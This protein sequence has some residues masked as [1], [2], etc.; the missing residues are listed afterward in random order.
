[1][2]PDTVKADGLAAVEA[3]VRVRMTEQVPPE[4][5]E[6]WLRGRPVVRGVWSLSGDCDYEIRVAA[7]SL[8]ELTA[9]LRALRHHGVEQTNT[10]LLLREIL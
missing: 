8:D 6:S 3:F 9:E 7:A 1:M 10:C 2:P 5:F 4:S